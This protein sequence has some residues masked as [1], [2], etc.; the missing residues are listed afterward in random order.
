MSKHDCYMIKFDGHKCL[1]YNFAQKQYERFIKSNKTVAEVELYRF[2][3]D[4]KPKYKF[5]VKKGDKPLKVNL[6]LHLLSMIEDAIIKKKMQLEELDRDER[7][8]QEEEILKMKELERDAEEWYIGYVMEK[9]K[10]EDAWLYSLLI[11]P[12]E[13]EEFQFYTPADITYMAFTLG[14][15][16]RTMITNNDINSDGIAD[17]IDEIVNLD[18]DKLIYLFEL[19]CHEKKVSPD[20]RQEI[21]RS[22]VD[23]YNNP[24]IKKR[25]LKNNDVFRN[26][27]LAKSKQ[28]GLK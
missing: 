12:T 21:V 23:K 4:K 20:Y 3:Y 13:C 9:A 26:L 10:Q 25:I 19:S 2:K 17:N 15:L 28:R 16:N 11:D 7:K 1:S 6:Y 18:I 14:M 8:K 5:I 24:Y 27:H 22:Y